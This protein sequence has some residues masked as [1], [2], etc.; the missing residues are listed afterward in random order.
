MNMFTSYGHIK[1][2]KYNHRLFDDFSLGQSLSVKYTYEMY[3]FASVFVMLF[4]N[5]IYNSCHY[6]MVFIKY[7][8]N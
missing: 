4:V 3:T 8:M 1:K 2:P 6:V 5:L 7:I